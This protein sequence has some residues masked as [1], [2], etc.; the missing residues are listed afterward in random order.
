VLDVGELVA[1]IKVDASEAEGGISDF[2]AKAGKALAGAGLLA[3]GL[4]AASLVKAMNMDA[5]ND[6]L[7]AQLGLSAAESKRIGGIAGDL[8][9]GAYGDSLDQVNEAI[10]GIT[11]NVG[12]GNDQW[13]KDT[14]A[15]VLNLSATF[16]QEAGAI[17]A[18]VGQM[19]NTGLAANSAEAL[20]IITAGFQ[21]GDD[22]AGDFLDTLNE[23]GTQFR[24]L[25]IDGATATA[26][27]SQGLKA[28]ARDGDLVADSIKEF[29]IRAI[30]GS[31]T[32]SDAYKSLGVDAKAM[33][34]QIAAGG[35]AAEAGLQTILD[36]LRAVEDPAK[37]AAT[38]TAL[39]GTQ[40][41]DLGQ[42]LF[43]LDP[44]GAVD[45]IGQ[46]AGAAERM[47]T[48]LNDNA[49]ANLE[50]F[51]RQVQMAFV[52]F[53]GAK[54][55]PAVSA[56][57]ASLN[58]NFVPA[59][60]IGI[61]KLR[62]VGAAVMSAVDFFKRHETAA[63]A[64]GAVVAG[65]AAAVIAAWLAQAGVAT[66]AAARSVIAWFITATAST[67][68]ATIQSRSTAQI[69]VG[70]L[71]AAVSAAASAAAVVAGWVASAVAATASGIAMAAAW[72]IALGPIAWVIAA[73]VLI[74][75]GL[76]LLWTQSETFRDIVIGVWNTVWGVIQ[77]VYG[78]VR[79]NWP[80]L[81]AILTGPIGVA[82]LVIS[83]NWD[84]IKAG[85]TAVKDWIVDAFNTVVGFVT[86]LGGRISGAAS[87]MW[88]GIADAFK[89]TL[90]WVIRAWNNLQFTTP[91]FDTHIPGIGSVGGQ[92]IG[93]PDIQEL[94]EGGIVR[95]RPGG[96][97]ANIGE[98]RHD[99]AVIPLDGK[100]G[101][102][103]D[104]YEITVM[105][106][107][108]DTRKMVRDMQIGQRDALAL[109]GLG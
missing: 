63:K 98:G 37:Q 26:L 18:A 28:G 81:L 42:A 101:L 43:A 102:G 69:V 38:A 52:D 48:T 16:D 61:E 88:N 23:Y 40:A 86:G 80:L 75:A 68:S 74:G 108:T 12:E 105:G 99:E 11:Q 97:I 31:K 49:S 41:E 60:Q 55:L 78:W 109:A 107:V 83:K 56:I 77:G 71:A 59:L 82:V 51:K 54:A 53:L 57:A 67:T 22:K 29:S 58:T 79:D 6:K 21:A 94:A 44:S 33:T 25:G 72:L 70:W 30:D 62:Q 27:I 17:S 3:G 8:Y 5:A 64:L 24:K 36:K 106:D 35:P 66:A 20:D 14:A 32:T 39:F 92:T 93:M 4:F 103:G 100:H 1:R 7:A 9:A 19:L 45:S 15:S 104:T 96:I 50:G 73:F 89:S 46:V 2:G 76:V 90:N 91:S 10:R 95:A 84:T 65:V 47:G 87:G 13:L 34:E 85:V